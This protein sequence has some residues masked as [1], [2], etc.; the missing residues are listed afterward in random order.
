MSLCSQSS[1]DEYRN[2]RLR[3]SAIVEAARSIAP[4]ALVF[5][6][7]TRK[8]LPKDIDLLLAAD[9]HSAAAQAL[10]AL[11][12]RHYGW[13]DIFLA[14]VGGRL[15]VRN[16]EATGYVKAVNAGSIMQA[17]E[18]EGIPLADFDLAAAAALTDD[19]SDLQEA[20]A[21]PKP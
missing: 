16:G 19:R 3:L 10:L 20:A 21:S 2:Q 18:S 6:S 4:Q 14:P 13:L 9:P 15:L 12:R 7:A 1:S 8:G 5:G 17:T 11:A